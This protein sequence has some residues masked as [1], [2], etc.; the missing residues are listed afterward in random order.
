[1]INPRWYWLFSAIV[2]IVSGCGGS[3]FSFTES[4]VVDYDSGHPS[5]MPVDDAGAVPP[6]VAPETSDAG[7]GGAPGTG[8]RT[9]TGGTTG[10]AGTVSAGGKTAT[11]GSSGGVTATGG[12]QGTGGHPSEDACVPVTHTNGVGQT[13]RDCV[14]VGTYDETQAMKAC[15]ARTG[16]RRRC[17]LAPGCGSAAQVVQGTG[18][19]YNLLWGFDGNTAGFVGIDGACPS[20]H[21]GAWQ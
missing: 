12:A 19:G 2:I 14:P 5:T 10:H 8:G 21:S 7:A 3:D 6:D 20:G 16:D 18:E 9:A 15:L 17:S 4:P 11:G 13:W 1:M